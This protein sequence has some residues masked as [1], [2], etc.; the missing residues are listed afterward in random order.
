VTEHS[1]G[2]R[3][4][5][6]PEMNAEMKIWIIENSFHLTIPF[7]GATVTP[8]CVQPLAEIRKFQR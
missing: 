3:S 6:Y 7:P 4:A 5:V 1:H 8:I 2:R